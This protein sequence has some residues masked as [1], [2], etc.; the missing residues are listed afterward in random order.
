MKD[1]SVHQMKR[2]VKFGLKLRIE[3]LPREGSKIRAVY[4]IFDRFKGQE[5]NFTELVSTISER[6]DIHSRIK[7]LNDMYGM[8]IIHVRPHTWKYVGE[9]IGSKYV[10]YR[11][12]KPLII[13]LK[14]KEEQEND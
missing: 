5:I 2:T 14:L 7:Y 6:K 4:D 12:A 11:V 13:R 10:D 3:R 1:Y 9:Y 8:D